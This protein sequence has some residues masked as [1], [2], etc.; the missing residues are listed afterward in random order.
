[1]ADKKVVFIAFAIEDEKMRDLFRGQSLNTQSPFEFIDMSV[2]EAYETGWK[3]KVRTRIKRSNGVL[4]LISKNSLNS[5]GQQW[6]IA[7]AK[8]EKK[9]IKGI[10][11]YTND[12]TNI[13]GVSTMVWTWENIANWIDGL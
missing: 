8:E 5:E 10:Y 1:M 13:P 3:D 2:K 12:R 7:C 4:V 6:E 11:I 9:P